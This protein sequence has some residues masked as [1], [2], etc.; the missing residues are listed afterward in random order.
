M[1]GQGQDGPGG[2]VGGAQGA[3]GRET[4][5][6]LQAVARDRVVDAGSDSVLLGQ[7]GGEAVAVLDADRVLVVDV[8]GPGGDVG[9]DDAAQLGVQERGVRLAP[10]RPVRGLA[11]LDP[12][13]GGADVGHAVVEPDHLVRVAPLHA[14][15]AQQ[16]HLALD[17]RVGGGD[18]APLAAGHVLRR[19][20]AER[21]ELPEAAHAAPVQGSAVGLGGVLEDHEAVGLGDGQDLVHRSGVAVQ[22]DRH[23][24]AGAGR[25]RLLDRGGRQRVGAQVDVGEDGGGPRDGDGVGGGGEGEGGH[26]HLVA[27]P[28]P[29]GQQ[30][31]VEG[32]GPRVDGDGAGPRR[33]G[34]RELLLEGGDLGALGD[35]ARAHDRGDGGDLLLADQG[36][37]RG[38]EGGAHSPSPSGARAPAPSRR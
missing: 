22:V 37:R 19:V 28:D 6:G 4:G 27:R 17:P 30:P 31:Q 11:Q 38:H 2:L 18:H 12:A 35:H 33:H 16:A 24:G 20:E 34:A 13:D 32:R 5:Q 29:G 10:A 15:V 9:G 23:D 25:D 8:D 7:G 3:G 1:D 14:L 36:A 21:P 26:D